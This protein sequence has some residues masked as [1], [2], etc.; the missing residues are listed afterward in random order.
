M[1]LVTE[2]IFNRF[3]DDC[4]GIGCARHRVHIHFLLRKHIADN[5]L[6]NSASWENFSPYFAAIERYSME[7]P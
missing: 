2:R 1:P 4:A 6:R 7:N 5:R 3:L